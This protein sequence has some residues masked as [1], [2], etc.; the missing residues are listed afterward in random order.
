MAKA[1]PFSFLIR[2]AA[3]A[4]LALI[5]SLARGER[6]NCRPSR[7]LRPSVAVTPLLRSTLT[8]TLPVNARPFQMQSVNWRPKI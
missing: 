6:L 2:V 8:C 5:A 7:H 3:A 4:V 1:G